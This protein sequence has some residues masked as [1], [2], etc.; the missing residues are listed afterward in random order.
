MKLIAPPGQ[1]VQFHHTL[2]GPLNGFPY[3]LFLIMRIKILMASEYG[4]VPTMYNVL[5]K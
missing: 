5:T 4:I 3:L 2:I 1:P